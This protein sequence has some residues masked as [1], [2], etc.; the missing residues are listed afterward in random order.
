MNHD[1]EDDL[2][3][4]LAALPLEEPPAG[5]RASILAATIYRPAFPIRLWEGWALGVIS[6]LMLWLVVLVVKGGGGAFVGS[7]E[8]LS[9][10]AWRA[11]SSPALVLWLALGTAIAMWMIYFNTYW[12]APQHI[13]R[14]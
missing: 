1:F 14:R 3:R 10:F 11:L 6:A 4:M 12:T 2:D 13:S 9:S 7:I 5:L 8:L